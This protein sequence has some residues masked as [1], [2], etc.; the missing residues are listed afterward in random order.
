MSYFI[1]SNWGS[2]SCLQLIIQSHPWR[3]LCR[4]GDLA[5]RYFAWTAP[6]TAEEVKEWEEGLWGSLGLIKLKLSLSLEKSKSK[7]ADI[8]I[9]H[10]TCHSAYLPD[11]ASSSRCLVFNLSFYLEIQI[12][13]PNPIWQ[14]M[15]CNAWPVGI[16]SSPSPLFTPSY[17]IPNCFIIWTT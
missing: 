12:S 2:G 14:L 15:D 6:P 13:L 10:V 1:F 7:A 4:E 3:Y 5:S 17:H 11:S 16:P 9:P 8:C